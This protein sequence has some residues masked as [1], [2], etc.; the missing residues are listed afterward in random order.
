MEYTNNSTN[1]IVLFADIS[2]DGVFF[3]QIL[4][5]FGAACNLCL[6]LLQISGTSM[7]LHELNVN[8]K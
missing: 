4:L 2:E 3:L 5:I 8:F 7:Y 6:F 1:N